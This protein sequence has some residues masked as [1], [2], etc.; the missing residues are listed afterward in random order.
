MILK[1]FNISTKNIMTIKKCKEK[2][3]QDFK[4][5][6]NDT[7][8]Y[9][10]VLW[11]GVD[12]NIIVTCP[13]HGDFNIRPVDHKRGRG[14]QKCS[15]ENKIK[16]DTQAFIKHSI[17]IWG[18]LYDYSKSVYIDS[19]H[20]INIICK[21]HGE[22]FQ[23]PSNHYKYKCRKCSHKSNIRNKNLNEKCNNEFISKANNVHKNYYDYS[24]IAYINAKTK[25]KIICKI[26]GEFEISPN[27]H[28]RGKGCAKC[29][30]LSSTLSKRKS[31]DEYFKEFANIF[32]DKYDYSHVKWEGA[33]KPID[34]KCKKHGFFSIIPYVHK[35]G[36]ECPKC[37]NQYSKTSIDWLL[38]IEI[39]YC[40]D[41]QHA[42]NKGEYII[43]GTRY[44]ADGYAESINT[45]FEFHGDFWHGNP[46]LYDKN[47]INPRTGL[48][49]GELYENTILKNKI[50]IN[51]G[52]NIIEVWE[53]D[54]KNFIKGIR[55]IQ[56]K[57]KNKKTFKAS[58]ADYKRR[59]KL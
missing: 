1:Y 48:T 39:K 58:V 42:K 8:N 45:I 22:F 16:S 51:K 26:H 27:N 52:Y 24:L 55:K 21:I 19:K 6:H 31:F 23:L 54:W 46:K 47:K 4:K 37:S 20:K 41:I 10:K 13:I 18:D 34:V 3:I 14:C 43:P 15:L 5:I 25:I 11:S 2:Y 49:Y 53:N 44:K 29:G 9:S 17:E 36:K 35:T 30:I 40:I 32:A 57:W 56:I 38:Y 12:S 50:I 33:C 28:L 59:F 7:Y